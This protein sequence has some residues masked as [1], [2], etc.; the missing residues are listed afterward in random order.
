MTHPG[1]SMMLATSRSFGDRNFKD[2]WHTIAL[3]IDAAVDAQ[4]EAAK[5][6]AAARESAPSGEEA[7][8]DYSYTGR[9]QRCSYDPGEQDRE[10]QQIQ[11]YC[12]HHRSR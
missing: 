9:D 6:E 2:S 8:E 3:Q 1:T 11:S 5:E 10:R 12:L 7:E 4:N